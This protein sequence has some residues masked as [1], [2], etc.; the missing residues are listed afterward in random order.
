MDA[1]EPTTAEYLSAVE[2]EQLTGTPASTWRYWAH[3]GSGPP[4]FKLGRRRVWKRSTAMAWLEN[5]EAQDSPS[6]T[7]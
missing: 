7:A 2:L 1:S 5:L 3:L 6:A 4:S